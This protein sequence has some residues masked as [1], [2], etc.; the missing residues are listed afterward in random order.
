MQYLITGTGRCGTV[1]CALLLNKIGI[2]CSH[3]AIFTYNGF[4]EQNID[5]EVENSFLSSFHIGNKIKC[6]AESSYMAAPYL[7]KIPN[8]KII[9]VLRNPLKVVKSYT[10]GLNF[11]A[12][13]TPDPYNKYENF[14]YKILP[15]LTIKMP[16]IDRCCLF[17]VM[18]NKL[19][20]RKHFTFKIENGLKQLSDFLQKPYVEIDPVN[21]VKDRE[22]K[23]KIESVEISKMLVD[24]MKEIGYSTSLFL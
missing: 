18:W 11:F 22:Y 1:S 12:N 23:I 16:Q 9:H 5:E 20:T 13:N 7:D 21:S 2:P 6:I 10:H 24:Y 19:I 4:I 17:Y 15:E 8:T 3:E 14:I